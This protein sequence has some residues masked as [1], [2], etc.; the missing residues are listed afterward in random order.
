MEK[1]ADFRRAGKTVG[2]VSHAMGSMRSLCDEA[3]W[4][5]RGEV[6]DVGLAAEV[7][8]E[9]VDASHSDREVPSEVGSRWGS[10]EA[11]IASVELVD[12]DGAPTSLVHTGERVTFRICYETQQR[13]QRPV[14]GLALESLE[15]V[16]LWAHHSRDGGLLVDE[17]DGSGSVDLEIPALM[18]QAGTFDLQA[19]IV[20]HTTT[21]TYD[22]IRNC[23]RFDVE[24]GQ[25]RES[26][27]LFALGGRWG[28]LQAGATRG[29]QIVGRHSGL[30]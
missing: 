27:G 23:L 13:V 30:K 15:G 21:H 25:P 19:S 4:L 2:I 17:I 29:A 18:L 9:Y 7:V 20:D 3:A 11:R 14:F 1:F 5:Y 24:S 10:G 12:S 6:Q 22:F 8:D 26:G 16:Y 28:N